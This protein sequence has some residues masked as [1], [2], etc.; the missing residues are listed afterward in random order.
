MSLNWGG[1][2]EKQEKLRTDDAWPNDGVPAKDQ[3]RTE[4]TLVF[5]R[6]SRVRSID[7]NG[8]LRAQTIFKRH[9]CRDSVEK[10][11]RPTNRCVCQYWSNCIIT[12]MKLLRD[13]FHSTNV[14]HPQAFLTKIGRSSS[15]A[16]TSRKEKINKYRQRQSLQELTQREEPC[17]SKNNTSDLVSGTISLL[18]T[19]SQFVK[20]RCLYCINWM[21]WNFSSPWSKNVTAWFDK[22]TEA[23]PCFYSTCLHLCVT[24]WQEVLCVGWAQEASEEEATEGG[25]TSTNGSQEHEEEVGTSCKNE[26]RHVDA[27]WTWSWTPTILVLCKLFSDLFWHDIYSRSIYLTYLRAIL[28]L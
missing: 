23:S 25:R 28:A 17:T 18:V 1:D 5:T 22:R 9:V 10:V 15:T 14:Q 4:Y 11:V 26:L 6:L 13:G 24:C 2:P 7:F 21:Y 16:T 19:L 12:S 27:D 20:L 3:R 8:W